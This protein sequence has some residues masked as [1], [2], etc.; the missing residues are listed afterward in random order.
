MFIKSFGINLDNFYLCHP[1]PWLKGG[2]LLR[3]PFMV[4]YG[5]FHIFVKNSLSKKS[6][7]LVTL[8]PHRRLQTLQDD[9]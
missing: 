5:H 7:I 6:D 9:E 3:G 8:G 4:N 1:L 2:P